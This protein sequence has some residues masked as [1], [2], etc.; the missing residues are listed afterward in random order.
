MKI[1]DR[2]PDSLEN[3][4]LP[5]AVAVHC[6]ACGVDLLWPRGA[7]NNVVCPSCGKTETLPVSE[8]DPH[9]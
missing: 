2:K 3:R 5:N 7:G 4:H 1:H 6:D 9:G 8:T